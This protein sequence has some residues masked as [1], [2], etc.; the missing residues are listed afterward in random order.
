MAVGQSAETNFIKNK[1]PKI[2]E[3]HLALLLDQERYIKIYL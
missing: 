1:N 3:Q 2:E